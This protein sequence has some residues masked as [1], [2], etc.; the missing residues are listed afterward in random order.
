MP[1]LSTYARARKTSFFFRDVPKECRILE[2]GCGAGWLGAYLRA[3][4]WGNY[5]GIDLKPPADIVGDIRDW[6]RLGLEPAS[7][8]VIAA[9]EVVE[10]VDCFADMHVLLKPGGLLMLTSPVPNMDWFCR[11]LEYLH[12][13]QPRTSPHDHLIRFED[14]PLFTPLI[15]RCMGLAAQWGI[16]RKL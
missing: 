4:G 14:I 12:L 8:D 1:L 3:N 2:I 15:I 7:F 16:F 13:T 10:H 5:V 6:R 9:F 11:L